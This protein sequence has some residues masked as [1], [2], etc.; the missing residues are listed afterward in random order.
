MIPS[1]YSQAIWR[2]LVVAAGDQE[3][4]RDLPL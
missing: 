2:D 3:D 4:F 1:R